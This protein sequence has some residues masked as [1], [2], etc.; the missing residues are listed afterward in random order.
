MIAET[1][2]YTMMK[3]YRGAK[4]VDIDA[5]SEVIRRVAMLAVD[6]PEITEIDVNPVFAYERG[7]AALDVKITLS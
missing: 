7:V 2:A 5:V 3:G 1:K 4:P 6:F